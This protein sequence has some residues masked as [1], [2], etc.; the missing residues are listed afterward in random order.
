MNTSSKQ[1]LYAVVIPAITL[2]FL[3][4]IIGLINFKQIDKTC[5][6]LN[7]TVCLSIDNENIKK[8]NLK[9]YGLDSS[10][11]KKN[12][13]V[14]YLSETPKERQQEWALY[15]LIACIILSL[16]I[17]FPYVFFRIFGS[18]GDIID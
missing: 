13:E 5:T 6:V 16:L 4:I 1:T 18:I 14:T 9:D 15:A 3:Y 8:I 7:S 2:L 17:R 11:Y 12:E 10:A